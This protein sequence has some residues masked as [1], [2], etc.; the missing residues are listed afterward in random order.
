MYKTLKLKTFL[1]GKSFLILMIYSIA[2]IYFA[3]PY[4]KIPTAVPFAAYPFLFYLFIHSVILFCLALFT[5]LKRELPSRDE[6][7]NISFVFL[8]APFLGNFLGMFIGE[9]RKTFCE[10]AIDLCEK[11]IQLDSLFNVDSD[12]AIN[13]DLVI[14]TYISIAFIIGIIP[15]Y[16]LV[17]LQQKILLKKGKQHEIF[18]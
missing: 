18:E 1:D 8:L 7:H 3:H 13:F 16:L 17:K 12:K 2:M 5:Y 15:S 9:Q 6:W 10:S 14:M 11:L 4:E